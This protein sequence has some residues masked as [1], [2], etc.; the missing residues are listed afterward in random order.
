MNANQGRVQ[1]A[2]RFHTAKRHGIRKHAVVGF[3]AKC[4]RTAKCTSFSGGANLI[5]L[6]TCCESLPYLGRSFSPKLF[7][8]QKMSVDEGDMH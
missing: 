4:A 6:R 7:C 2:S 8:E 1:Q 5:Y 3:L